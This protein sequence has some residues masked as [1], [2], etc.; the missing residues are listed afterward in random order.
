MSR[1]KIKPNKTTEVDSPNSPEFR[2]AASNSGMKILLSIRLNSARSHCFSFHQPTSVLFQGVQGPQRSQPA[3]P[4]SSQTPH[5]QSQ[6]S[7]LLGGGA[8]TTDSPPSCAY[9]QLPKPSLR[10]AASLSCHDGKVGSALGKHLHKLSSG[11]LEDTD[12]KGR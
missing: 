12:P 8:G 9:K 7:S 1:V 2:H 10:L 4:S 11:S 5:G 6:G 3:N